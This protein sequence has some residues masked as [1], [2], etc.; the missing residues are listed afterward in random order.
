MSTAKILVVD[1]EALLVKGIRFNLKN[2]GY[3]VITGSDGVV[4]GAPGGHVDTAAGAKYN[5]R[6]NA[7][8]EAQYYRETS[9]RYEWIN[10]NV[11]KI[12]NT[13]VKFEDFKDDR[14]NII[15]LFSR[16]FG[17]KF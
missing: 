10:L 7:M 4:R 2:E 13:N 9:T 3:E 16:F 8:G 6:V 14:A 5:A 15:D 1:D 11:T 17:E 12:Y